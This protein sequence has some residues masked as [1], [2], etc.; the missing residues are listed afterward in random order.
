MS[1]LLSDLNTQSL[2]KRNR[3]FYGDNLKIMEKMPL[4]CVDMIYLDPPFN[5]N[6]TYNL[7]YKQLTGTALPEQENAFCDT[8]VVPV[9][10]TGG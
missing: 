8:E 1:N 7:I 5:S 9:L 10:W 6:R 2:S 3:L 4:A